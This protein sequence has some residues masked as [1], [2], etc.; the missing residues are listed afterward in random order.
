MI[1]IP[2]HVASKY[3]FITL[4]ALRCDQLMRGARP[5][6]DTRAHRPTTIALEEILAGLVEERGPEEVAIPA[7]ESE[8][9]VFMDGEPASPLPA[10]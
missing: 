8:E 6:L 4:A 5:R 1:C 7:P 2:Q 3:R 9:A 10:E